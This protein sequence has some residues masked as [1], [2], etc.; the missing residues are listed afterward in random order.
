MV[1]LGYMYR[2]RLQF[3]FTFMSNLRIVYPISC[4]T[5]FMLPRVLLLMFFSLICG[6]LLFY[7]VKQ[8]L[9]ELCTPNIVMCMVYIHQQLRHCK[10]TVATHTLDNACRNQVQRK[11]C[12]DFFS[13]VSTF[14]DCFQQSSQLLLS[15]LF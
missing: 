8:T 15:L 10:E 6:C 11:V 13:I 7:C 1:F 9:S 14:E 2:F 4:V 3:N 12:L 5:Y